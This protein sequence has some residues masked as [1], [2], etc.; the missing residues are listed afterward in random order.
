MDEAAKTEELQESMRRFY[1]ALTRARLRLT[2]YWGKT[3]GYTDTPLSIAL[4]GTCPEP[5]DLATAKNAVI[6]SVKKRID[7]P[8]IE[9]VLPAI[10]EAN[11]AMVIR[12]IEEPNNATYQEPQAAH[13]TL[14]RAEFMRKEFDLLWKA[15]SYSGITERIGKSRYSRPTIL[16]DDTEIDHDYDQSVEIEQDRTTHFKLTLAKPERL[17]TDGGLTNVPLQILEPVQMPEHS[18]ISSTKKS[19]SPPPRIPPKH[20]IRSMRSLQRG[21]LTMAWP[22]SSGPIRIKT[23][24]WR[25]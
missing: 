2:L 7:K 1:V 11:P 8:G 21:A 25:H 9:P 19:T 24:F 18:C 10:Q 4:V 3:R 17:D 14:K 13:I 5:F 23:H 15:Q 22:P 20:A 12:A 16:M 6:A